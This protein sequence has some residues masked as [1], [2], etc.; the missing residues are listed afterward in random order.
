[1]VTPVNIPGIRHALKLIVPFSIIS[2]VILTKWWYAIPVDGPDK[3]YWGFPFPFMGEGFHTSMSLQL[4]VFELVVDFL[5]YFLIWCILFFFFHI[6]F[7]VKS[8]S[9]I[10]IKFSWSLALLC[11]LGFVILISASNPVIRL[12]RDYDWQLLKTGYVFIWQKT[13]RPDI[14][15]FK[16]L[17]DK[18]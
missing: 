7:Q 2:L 11:V 8:I 5:S 18:K 15:E 13:P 1:M 12:R 4:F 14:E 9:K 6:V 16:F 17:H 3:L 10:L